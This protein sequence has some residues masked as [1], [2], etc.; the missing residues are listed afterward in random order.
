MPSKQ[1]SNYTRQ[2][3]LEHF[4]EIIHQSISRFGDKDFIYTTQGSISF[5]ETNHRA[6]TIFSAL[7]TSLDEF[8]VGVGMFM[9]DPLK[10]VPSMLGIMKAQ[11]YVIP[12]DVSVPAATLQY[13]IENAG[14]K[15]I[16]VVDKYADQLRRL[17][18]NK[19]TIVN[20]DTL[21]YTVNIPNPVVHHNPA[22]VLQILFTSG[23]TG[24]P[25]GA[26]EDYRYLARAIHVKLNE[27]KYL[28]EDRFLQLSS[29]TYSG[30][31]V[32]VFYA[33][34]AGFTLCVYNLKDDGF[35][36]LSKWLQDT[37]ITIFNANPTAFRSFVS[38]LTPGE[39]FPKV[40]IAK[41]GGEKRLS[42]DIQAMK[43]HF[44][45]IKAIRSN[46]SST[47]TQAVSTTI[48]PLDAKFDEDVIPSGIPYK[49]IKVY[50]WDEKGNSLPVGEEGEIVVNGD[51]LARGYINNPELTRQ[52]F[53]PDPAHPDWQYFKTGDL[54]KLL[55]NGQLIHLGRMDNMV[56]IKGVRIELDSIE[57]HLLDYPGIIQVASK[58]IEDAR[59]NK[60]LATYFVAEKG[61]EVPISDLRKHLAESLPSAM[62]PHYLIRLP[63]FPLTSNGKVALSQLPLPKL[64][65]PPL[66]HDLVPPCDETEVKLT[67]IWEELLGIK[68]IGVTDD[69]F[70]VGGDSLLGVVLFVAIEKEFARSLPVSTLLKA[71][72]IREQAGILANNDTSQDFIPVIPINTG[73]TRIPLFFI[74]GKGG[75]PTR[76][77]HL[78]K[79][80]DPQ[81]PVYALQDLIENRTA[82]TVRSVQATASFYLKEIKKIYQEGPYILVGESA[83][84]K[85][86]YEIA[87]QLLKNGEPKPL[88]I[89]LDTY[90]FEDSVLDEYRAIKHLPYYKMLVQK[91]L[92]IFFHSKWNGKLE[93]LRFYRETIG[94]KMRRFI[95]KH[96]GSEV[97]KKD[98]SVLPVNYQKLEREIL[99]ADRKYR[100]QPY[101]GR[102]ILFKALRGTRPNNLS[103]DWDKV[104][105]GDLKIHTLDCY[106]GSMLFDP[107]IS[108]IA[109]IIQSYIADLEQ[110]SI[111]SKARRIPTAI[112]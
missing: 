80:I 33:L 56:K 89:L 49:D 32:S 108:Q 99:E 18:G 42:N 7:K 2:E 31:H 73:G 30:P 98:P 87:Q 110:S 50:I 51:A 72:T 71:P 44:S 5:K 48:L 23:S 90:N 94:K 29:F 91:H 26:I 63:E 107:A 88:V 46:F 16:L 86:A 47:E 57:N 67:G 103:N 6:N 78:A 43:R 27:Y 106:H 40:R 3:I 111:G 58:P 52:R 112:I 55:P 28:P 9:K 12:L 105:I 95:R 92:F 15:I 64:T 82:R 4:W 25:K 41:L 19:T 81:T 85:I 10:V 36:G 100:V 66:S 102:V 104:E 38:A 24:Q 8:H 70:D 83:G 62:L 96:L 68:G 59:G 76:I 39:Q 1:N 37:G 97:K 109:A 14:I 65:R 93:Y 75:Y 84:G 22:D 61:I 79:K 60:K 21:D 74:P 34:L 35:V 13:M 69:F 77:R 53:I 11:D 20:I 101:P 17:I 45:N 54:G